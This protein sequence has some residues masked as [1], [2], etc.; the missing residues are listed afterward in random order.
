[1]ENK[2]SRIGPP[3]LRLLVSAAL[4]AL[5][6]LAMLTAGCGKSKTEPAGEQARVSEKSEEATAPTGAE[7]AEEEAEA[8]EEEAATEEEA[9]V[10]G[11]N[12]SFS[13]EKQQIGEG[14]YIH[15]LRIADIRWADHGDYF[16]IVFEVEKS[17]G[18]A[19]TEVPNCYTLYPASDFPASEN[20][21]EL[22]ISFKDIPRY[23]YDY[24][25]F[26]ADD[27]PVSLGDTL[28]KTLERVGVADTEQLRF[29]ISCAYSEAH[30][31][32]SSRPHRLMYATNPMRVILDIQ[33]M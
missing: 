32:V 5:L 13:L 8:G 28:V 29:K 21:H 15:D 24:P 26:Q 12:A 16:R 11:G 20:Y 22:F 6:A 7:T 4:A 14:G 1:M 18:S 17:D 19:V 3:W 33:K 30:P 10:T 27:T 31:G 25:E 23:Q 2:A 9:S